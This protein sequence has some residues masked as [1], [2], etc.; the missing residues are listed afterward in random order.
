[1]SWSSSS[2]LGA[3]PHRLL[4]PPHQRVLQKALPHW[5]RDGDG[6]PPV[7]DGAYHDL[8][9]QAPVA[10]HSGIHFASSHSLCSH[11]VP[12]TLFL[13]II[14]VFDRARRRPGAVLPINARVH[15]DGSPRGAP[16]NQNTLQKTRTGKEFNL[17]RTIRHRRVSQASHVFG[18]LG[19]SE[20]V[21]PPCLAVALPCIKL[22]LA[23]FSALAIHII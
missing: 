19:Y 15:H 23:R 21:M 20:V 11:I 12:I 4:R 16:W 5:I 7:H 9:L 10:T 8:S 17:T 13:R 2:N 6:W 1:M 18:F 3:I 22:P 14:P